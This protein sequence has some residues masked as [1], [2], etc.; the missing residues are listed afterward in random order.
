MTRAL[1]VA[2]VVSAVLSSTANAQRTDA[3]FDRANQA[4][5]R[6]DFGEAVAGYE[7]LVESGVDDPDV[8]YNLATANARLGRWGHAIRWYEHALRLSPGDDD[9]ERGLTIARAA[10]GRQRADRDGEAT[11]QMRPS[12][13]QALVRPFSENT[14]A[15]LV[16]F[17]SFAFFGTLIARR[18]TRRETP[19]LA[20]GIA[21]PLTGLLL[22]LAAVG[23]VEKTG[24][25]TDGER[26]IVLAEDA[27]VREG[28]DHRARTRTSALE[29]E[30]AR[31]VDRHGDWV[32]VTLPG[33]REGWMDASD[34]G[35]I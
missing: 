32:H 13:A 6:G 15:W 10:L 24:A 11:V 9:A 7:L 19:R 29:G 3:I 22:A 14:L 35:A 4:Y 26:A 27:E 31:I 8:S 21:I 28:P 17:T 1:V 20:L 30:A 5:F 12:F 16:L 25:F 2:A 34:V 33:G 23:L 18:F